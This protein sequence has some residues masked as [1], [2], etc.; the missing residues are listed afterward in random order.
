MRRRHPMEVEIR[1]LHAEDDASAAVQRLDTSCFEGGERTDVVS[2]LARPFTWAWAA[3]IPAFEGDLAWVGY[4]LTWLVADELHVLNVATDP[5]HRRRGIGRALVDQAVAFAKERQVRIVLLE[6]RRGNQPAIRLYRSFG[7]SVLG[8]R[9]G[10]YS[11]NGEDALEMVL[12][13]DPETGDIV[14]SRDEVRLEEV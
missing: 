6:V 1:A 14:P 3:R 9:R 5:S 8:L 7:F 2:E 4:I 10:Y 11:D 12:V 13:L